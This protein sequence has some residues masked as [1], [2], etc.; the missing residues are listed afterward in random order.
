M[1][2]CNTCGEERQEEFYACYRTICKKCRKEKQYAFNRENPEYLKAKN[3]R[4]RARKLA[5]PNDLKKDEW[6]AIVERFGGECCLTNSTNIVLEHVVPLENMHLGTSVNNVVPMDATLN[7]SKREKN[8]IEWVFEPDVKPLINWE[9]F[10]KLIYYLAELNGMTDGQYI[11]FL[12]FCS[13]N[14][15]TLEEV[16]AAKHSS[17]ELF[18]KQQTKINQRN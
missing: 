10:D 16:K 11:D 14:K 8:L 5:L 1:K 17:V 4:R 13:E 9:K 6:K 3:Q 2:K 18:L 15:R 12:Y 7:Q